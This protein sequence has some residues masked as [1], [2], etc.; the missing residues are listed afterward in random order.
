M[1]CCCYLRN[2]QEL[3]LDGK[4]LYERRIGEPFKGPV[5]PFGSMVEYHP[6]SAK[7]QSRLHQIREQ[8]FAQKMPRI[9]IGESGKETHYGSRP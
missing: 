7:Y 4:T 3:L 8:S 1:E 9:C 2:I 6:I 5:I